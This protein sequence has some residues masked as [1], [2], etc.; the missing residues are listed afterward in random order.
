MF[1]GHKG[2][3]WVCHWPT[4]L[5]C[6][7]D[8]H[9]SKATWGRNGLCGSRVTVHHRRE[10]MQ[11]LSAGSWSRGLKQKLGKQSELL[12]NWLALRGF[13]ACFLIQPRITCLPGLPTLAW[14]LPPWRSIKK[15]HHSLA[16]RS[17]WWRQFPLSRPWQLINKQTNKQ[18]KPF[19]WELLT[20]LEV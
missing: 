8:T 12:T 18:T 11:E 2:Q 7:C 15:M 6:C 5:L 17:I 4:L 19:N 14:A 13:L 20:H 1:L 16:Y 3:L 10:P 9:W